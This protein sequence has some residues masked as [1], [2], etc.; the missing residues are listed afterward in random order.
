[1]PSGTGVVGADDLAADIEKGN[2]NFDIVI[3][4]PDL[5]P[6]VTTDVARAVTEFK[7][8]SPIATSNV[9]SANGFFRCLGLFV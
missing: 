1:M 5:M 9:P 2:M 8:R 3:A 4:T 6:I 7:G